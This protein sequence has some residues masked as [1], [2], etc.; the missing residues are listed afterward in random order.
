MKTLFQNSLLKFSILEEKRLVLLFEW[1]DRT[2]EMV[3]EDFQTACHTYAGFAW[4]YQVQHLL[5]DTRHF[6]FRLPEAFA[7]WREDQL[8]PR[9]Y[10][11]GVKKFAYL[12]LPESLPYMKDIPAT[13]GKF[14]TRN[15][16]AAEEARQW[17]IAV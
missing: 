14:E 11:L 15:F 1:T 12:T 3:Y 10:D 16:A 2:R 17:L 5:V 4:Q 13:D 6:H 8:N 9:Y 7:Q